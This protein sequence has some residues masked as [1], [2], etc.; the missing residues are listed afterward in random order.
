MDAGAER[1]EL[2]PE[3]EPFEK[4]RLQL[5]DL[6]DMYWEQSGRA[7]GVPVVFL[8]GGP[9]AGASPLHRRFFDPEHYRIIIFD[10]RGA[11]YSKPPAEVRDNT[12]HHLIGD[13]ETLRRHLGVERWLVFG[14]SW[15]AALGLTYGINHPQRCLGFVMRG[16]FLCR[17]REVDWFLD[18][19]RTIYPEAWRVFAAHVG[20]QEKGR[21]LEAYYRRLIDPDPAVHLAAAGAWSR[22]ETACSKLLHIAPQP[23]AAATASSALGLALL[24]AH[25]FVNRMFLPDG[26]LLGNVHLL[27]RIP[28]VIVQGRYD[29]ICPIVNADEL[30]RA[31]PE[32]EYVV[33]PEAGHSATEPGI[34]SALVA[35]TEKLKTRG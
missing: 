2:F 7:D 22:Y 6:H 32:A 3:I 30:A 25:Y 21:L 35:A 11:G 23:A 19:M 24:E 18:G 14:G 28:A 29:I 26:F 27:R 31:W 5:D 34:R 4:G 9:G 13:M 20:E 17:Q 16:V 8:H 1:F 12:T 10:Q 15:G 33:V